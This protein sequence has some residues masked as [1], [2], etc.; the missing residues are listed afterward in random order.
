MST[1]LKKGRTRAR[2]DNI[3]RIINKLCLGEL[4]RDDIGTLLGFSPSGTRKYIKD[5]KDSDVIVL[6][7]Y[8]DPT[9]QCLG[10]PLYRLNPDTEKVDAFL[11]HLDGAAMP[12]P[13][14]RSKPTVMDL[15]MRDSARHFH[16]LKSDDGYVPTIHRGPVA[17]D[18]MVAALFGTPAGAEIEAHA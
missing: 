2:V 11:A 18:P 3:K 9:P 10:I 17:R 4:L 5:L 1:L 7:R 8:V 16:V 6:V 12:P 13:K 15:A 14:G